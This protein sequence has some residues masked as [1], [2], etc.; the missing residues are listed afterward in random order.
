[1]RNRVRWRSL[2]IYDSFRAVVKLSGVR[3]ACVPETRWAGLSS[4]SV[5]RLNDMN[6]KSPNPAIL[7]EHRLMGL[8]HGR[9]GP[10][11]PQPLSGSTPV[12]GGR[13]NG[14]AAGRQPP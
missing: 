14:R 4:F 6:R 7:M 9:I 5:P 12:S 13:S 8:Q 10:R 3:Y 1:M 2:I 11:A